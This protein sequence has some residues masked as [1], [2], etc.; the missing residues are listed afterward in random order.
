[1]E[2]VPHLVVRVKSRKSFFPV[3]LT[4]TQLSDCDSAA[5]SRGAKTRNKAAVAN[6]PG[7]CLLHLQAGRR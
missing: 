4:V 6:R 7:G 2:D 5:Q 1:M 3:I